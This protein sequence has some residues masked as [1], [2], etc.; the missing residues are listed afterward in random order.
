MGDG[1]HPPSLKCV[2]AAA[3]VVATQHA[4]VHCRF[5][6]AAAAANA[7][8]ALSVRPTAGSRWCRGRKKALA[9][10]VGTTALATT[11][12]IEIRILRLGHEPVGESEQRGDAAEG[13][14]CRHHQRRVHA[15]FGRRAECFRHR[16]NARDLRHHLGKQEDHESCRRR[17]QSRHGDEGSRTDAIEGR[18][19]AHRT[20]TGTWPRA[21]TGGPQSVERISGSTTAVRQMRPWI[22]SRRSPTSQSRSEARSTAAQQGEPDRSQSAA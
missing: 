20:A 17:R 19:K 15:F 4:C 13:K 5:P 6:L 12:A 7:A 1:T 3:T 18:Q 2:L 16:I 11:A 22:R 21:P 9:I 10:R 14:P 8:R